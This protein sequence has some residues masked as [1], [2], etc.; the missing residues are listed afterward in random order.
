MKNT[1]QA[2]D[3]IELIPLGKNETPAFDEVA[4]LINGRNLIDLVGEVEAAFTEW[5]GNYAGLTAHMLGLPSELLLGRATQ[6]DKVALL[7]CGDCGDIGC[8]PIRARIT[9]LEDRVVW[10]AFEQPHRNGTDS[11]L[12]FWDYG[13]LGPFSFEKQAYLAALAAI[14]A[15]DLRRRPVPASLYRDPIYGW[16]IDVPDYLSNFAPGEQLPMLDLGASWVGCAI[17][18]TP[19]TL[20][21]AYPSSA[22][23]IW[24]VEQ[25]TYS[26]RVLHIPGQPDLLADWAGQWIDLA[27]FERSHNE[28]IFAPGRVPWMRKATG[29]L[30]RMA[31]LSVKINVLVPNR[32][33]GL[34]ADPAALGEIQ[35]RSGRLMAALAEQGQ[36]QGGTPR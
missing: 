35:E 22:G 34:V 6:G 10:E 4:I 8:W 30:H 25:D 26:V 18:D 3:R 11:S 5:P 17:V 28:W 19:R 31:S 33:Y 20:W 1:R 29:S 13:A 7:C 32:A 14:T 12:D 9:M 36:S 15:P 2:H 24:R 23:T 16:S 21:Y 27:L